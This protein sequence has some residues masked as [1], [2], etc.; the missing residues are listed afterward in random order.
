MKIFTTLENKSTVILI[1]IY[2]TLVRWE[3]SNVVIESTKEGMQK[4]AA[5]GIHLEKKCYAYVY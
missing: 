2:I 4:L 1:L 3:G 5:V